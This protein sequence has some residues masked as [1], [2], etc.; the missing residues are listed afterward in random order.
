MKHRG[1][2]RGIRIKNKQKFQTL[3]GDIDICGSQKRWIANTLF[4]EFCDRMPMR[5]N[6]AKKKD[7]EFIYLNTRCLIGL[8]DARF[9]VFELNLN[10]HSYSDADTTVNENDNNAIVWKTTE[11]KKGQTNTQEWIFQFFTLLNINYLIVA[12]IEISIQD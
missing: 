8:S 12:F 6:N 5:C 11:T 1:Y 10:H 7:I 3:S 2:T 9:E 4:I